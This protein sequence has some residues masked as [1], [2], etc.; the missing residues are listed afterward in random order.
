M[1]W[2][3]SSF[4]PDYMKLGSLR[5]VL[6]TALVIA[7]T[8]TATKTAQKH[9]KAALCMEKSKVVVESPDR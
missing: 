7:L 4:R 8:A 3:L 9:I 2:G 1:S 5:A 6:D